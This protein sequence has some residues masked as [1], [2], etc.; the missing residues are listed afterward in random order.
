MF[1][2][3][4]F[5]KTSIHPLSLQGLYGMADAYLQR[6]TTWTSRQSI[7]GAKTKTHFNP[8]KKHETQNT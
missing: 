3:N 5:F 2:E 7:T 4:A 1:C 8:P 6:D